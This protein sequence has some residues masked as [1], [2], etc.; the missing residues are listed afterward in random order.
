MQRYHNAVPNSMARQHDGDYALYSDAQAEIEKLKSEMVL[1]NA[2]SE[3][4]DR[5][6]GEDVQREIA[7]ERQI[8]A[9]KAELSDWKDLC[10]ARSLTTEQAGKEE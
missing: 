6:V 9:L 2:R 10:I 1:V 7:L 5:V 3:S 8:A 4:L